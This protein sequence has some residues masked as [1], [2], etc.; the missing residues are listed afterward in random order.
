MKVSIVTDSAA[1]LPA[2]LVRA[3]DIHVVPLHLHVG[4]EHHLDGELELEALVD[5]LDQHV[6][7]AAPT[8]GEFARTLDAARR[9]GP[10]VVLTVACTMSS[11][12]QSAMLAAREIG[13]GVTVIDT[14]AAAGAQA[15][16]V[17]HAARAAQAGRSV[18]EVVAAA[19][20]AIEQVRL[21]ATVPD[22]AQLA[23]SGRVPE[24]A[25]RIGSRV[26]VQPLFELRKGKV[27]PLRPAFSRESAL[28]RIVTR[29][30]DPGGR[31]GPLHVA[32]LHAVAPGTAETLRARV[33][34]LRPASCFVGPFSPVMVAH[35]GAGLA[36]LAWWRE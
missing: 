8:P 34:S 2:E 18:D 16:V 9:D 28:D 21:V 11:T 15:L 24:A 20:E 7:T 1:A 23:R 12:Y 6:T 27:R 5:R 10:V 25:R 31:T 14:L 13:S 35:T 17:L 32:V 4:D 26:G 3:H 30:A 22:L 36:G 19:R 29:C 33:E